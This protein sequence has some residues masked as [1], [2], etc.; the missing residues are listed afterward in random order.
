MIKAH[1]RKVV[2]EV[3]DNQKSY[4]EYETFLRV[5]KV[6]KFKF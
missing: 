5:A 1:F 2:K 3:N 4:L 6:L